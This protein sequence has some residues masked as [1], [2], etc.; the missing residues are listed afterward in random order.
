MLMVDV[1]GGVSGMYSSLTNVALITMVAF[2][3]DW[4]LFT[5]T[6]LEFVVYADVIMPYWFWDTKTPAPL[7]V[8]AGGVGGVG[9]YISKYFSE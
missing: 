4:P 5:I 3:V 9:K 2:T 6:K 1:W 8:N 7:T